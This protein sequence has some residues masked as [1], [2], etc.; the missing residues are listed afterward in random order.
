MHAQ[1]DVN[2]HILRMFE[3]TYSLGVAK[4]M[5]LENCRI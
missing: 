5:S 2:L 4:L 3:G 1:D